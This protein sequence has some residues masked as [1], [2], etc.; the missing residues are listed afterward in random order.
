MWSA[1]AN[2]GVLL[3]ERQFRRGADLG[4]VAPWMAERWTRITDSAVASARILAT[5]GLEQGRHFDSLNSVYTF[6]AWRFVALEWAKQK[7]GKELPREAVARA[8]EDHS[9]RLLSRWMLIPQWAGRWQDARTFPGYVRDLGLLWKDISATADWEQ[10]IARW[11]ACMDSWIRDAR[12]DAARFVTNVHAERRNTVRRYYSL[13]WTWQNLDPQRSR[14]AQINLTMK[15]RGVIETD[16]DHV[17]SYNQWETEFTGALA[18]GETIDGIKDGANSIGNCLLL[19]KN[20]N[21]SK[22]EK[23]LKELLDNVYEFR[24]N[25][26]LL[27][28][29]CEALCIDETMLNATGRPLTEVRAAVSARAERIRGDLLHFVRGEQDSLGGRRRRTA[30]GR[31]LERDVDDLHG[32]QQERCEVDR[33]HGP[34]AGG[35]LAGR[36]ILRGGRH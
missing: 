19:A 17:V 4:A 11:A 9:R 36:D 29:F 8:V 31:A 27:T 33:D 25:E 22:R 18:L 24:W 15:G 32:R 21:I 16:V 12:D 10:A 13:L 2:D 3:T 6:W 35:G 7:A 5:L 30:S 28:D 1:L 34:Q 26:E 14:L 20:F 23:P